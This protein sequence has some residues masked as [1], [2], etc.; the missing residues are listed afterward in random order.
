MNAACTLSGLSTVPRPSRVVIARPSACRT[1]VEHDRAAL[2][3][4]RT[5]HAPHCPRPHPNLTPCSPSELRK[6]Y[7]SG[8]AGSHESTLTARPFTRKLYLAMELSFEMNKTIS[9]RPI[10]RQAS[11]VHPLRS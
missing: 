5:V 7:K 1:G 10:Q 2:P 6:T 4:N 11:F 3:S 9:L 8:C